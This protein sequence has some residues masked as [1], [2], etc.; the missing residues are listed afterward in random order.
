MLKIKAAHQMF[1]L[2]TVVQGFFCTEKG[3]DWVHLLALKFLSLVN[4]V[5]L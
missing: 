4:A 2:M 3:F 5:L 1:F